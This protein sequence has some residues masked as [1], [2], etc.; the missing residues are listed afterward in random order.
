[1]IHVVVMSAARGQRDELRSRCNRC[2]VGSERMSAERVYLCNV[3]NPRGVGCEL[4]VV[5]RRKY[6][7]R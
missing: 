5:W 6:S 7:T 3:C 2:A 1:M 4:E